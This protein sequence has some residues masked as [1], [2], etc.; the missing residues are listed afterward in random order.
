MSYCRMGTDSDVYLIATFGGWWCCGCRLTD[1]TEVIKRRA[2]VLSH[3]Q[4]HKAAGHKV[5]QRAFQRIEREI[6]EASKRKPKAIDSIPR[7]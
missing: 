3:L 7:P 6:A 5:P 4:D 2:A 1:G